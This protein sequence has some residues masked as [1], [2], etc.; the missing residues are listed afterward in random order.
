MVPGWMGKEKA[1]QLEEIVHRNERTAV[2]R[3]DQVDSS[4]R[5]TSEVDTYDR[6]RA[7]N[8]WTDCDDPARTFSELVCAESRVPEVDADRATFSL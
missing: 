5:R 6:R 4:G 1:T 8:R 2:W 3:A 7:P